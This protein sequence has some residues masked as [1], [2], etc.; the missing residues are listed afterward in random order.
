MSKAAPN[1]T[2]PRKRKATPRQKVA[3]KKRVAKRPYVPR[4]TPE[5]RARARTVLARLEKAYPDWGPTLEFAD[6][7]QLLVAT[8]LA[9]QAQ[10]ERIN[11]VTRTVVFPKY[12]TAADYVAVKTAVLER[13]LKPTGFFRQKT[14]AVKGAALG[15]VERFGGE[16]PRDMAGLTSLHGVGRKTASIVLANAFGVPAIAVDRHVARVAARLGFSRQS[17][18][19]RIEQDLRAVFREPD[20]VKATWNL[21]LHGRRICNPTPKCPECPVIDLC[22]YPRKTK[23]PRSVSRAIRRPS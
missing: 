21:I 10:D 23:P 6:P 9:A 13:D 15:I 5:V 17:D 8:I 14:K 18:P 20:W 2:A 1:K 7:L 22:P 19:D 12:R 3:P 11:Q 4:V 16:V